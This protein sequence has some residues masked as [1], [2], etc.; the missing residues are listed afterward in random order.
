MFNN[1][2]GEV[3]IDSPAPADN[4]RFN[5]TMMFIQPVTKSFILEGKAVEIDG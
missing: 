5:K 2:I 3:L 1:G 4:T